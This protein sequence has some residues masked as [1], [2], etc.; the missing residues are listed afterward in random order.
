MLHENNLQNTNQDHQAHNQNNL[1]N[2]I[3]DNNPEIDQDNGEN[4]LEDIE[5]VFFSTTM[6]TAKVLHI[7]TSLAKEK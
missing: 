7:F 1:E 6:T 2:H 3:K 5:F 4:N